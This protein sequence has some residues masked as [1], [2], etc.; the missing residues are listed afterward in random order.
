M[1]VFEKRLETLESNMK[2]LQLSFNDIITSTTKNIRIDQ[3][4]KT[5]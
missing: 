1:T 4:R 2:I 5:D 3:K